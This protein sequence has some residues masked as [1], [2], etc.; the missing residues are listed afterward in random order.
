MLSKEEFAEQIT[1]AVRAR[2]PHAQIKERLEFGIKLTSPEWRL[3]PVLFFG[4]PY[5]AYLQHPEQL[6]QIIDQWLQKMDA[7]QAHLERSTSAGGSAA[8]DTLDEAKPY[9]LPI[10]RHASWVEETQKRMASMGTLKDRSATMSMKQLSPSL[11]V[12]YAIDLPNSNSLV[13]VMRYHQE[14]WQV[15]DEALHAMAIENLLKQSQDKGGDC[16]AKGY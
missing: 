11:F 1:A 14:D 10:L 6:Q 7:E 13:Y 16:E 12:I 2:H 4:N 5:N 9:I 15:S 8:R 3:E